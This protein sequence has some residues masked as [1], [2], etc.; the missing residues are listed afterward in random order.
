MKVSSFCLTSCYLLKGQFQFSQAIFISPLAKAWQGAKASLAFVAQEPLCIE[1]SCSQT[2]SF[3]RTVCIIC[4]LLVANS[5][6]LRDDSLIWYDV[7]D[8]KCIVA[9]AWKVKKITFNSSISG[10]CYNNTST[11]AISHICM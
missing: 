8:K 9:I 4:C 1:R 3:W 11:R 5:N 6:I 10:Y 7:K 2:Q